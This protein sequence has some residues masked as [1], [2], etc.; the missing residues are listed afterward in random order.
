[1][2]LTRRGRA[3]AARLDG[4]VLRFESLEVGGLAEGGM[5][6]SAF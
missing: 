2:L 3:A 1:M 6:G 5:G 4:F